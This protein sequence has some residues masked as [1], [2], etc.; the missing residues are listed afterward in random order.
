TTAPA[1]RAAL[2]RTGMRARFILEER[3]ADVARV[4]CALDALCLASRS[5]GFPNVLG[6]AM[7]CGRPAI[8]TD[9]G[10]VRDIVR[11]ERLIARVGAVGSLAECMQRVLELTPEQR[12][13]WGRSLRQGVEERYDIERIWERYRSLYASL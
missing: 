1:I 2:T 13:A 5:E 11:D 9:V 4:M 12:A 6:E 3:R 8:A 10:D 7:A